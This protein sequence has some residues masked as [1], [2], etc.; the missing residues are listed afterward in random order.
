MLEEKTQN[1][2][3]RLVNFMARQSGADHEAQR[4]YDLRGVMSYVLPFIRHRKEAKYCSELVADS[5]KML[6]WLEQSRYDPE[7]ITKQWMCEPPVS[8]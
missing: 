3:I 4:K 6:G 7:E 1:Y 8:L 5:F 2:R